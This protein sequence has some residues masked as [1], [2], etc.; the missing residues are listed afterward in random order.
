MPDSFYVIH[1][2]P[3]KVFKTPFFV[4]YGR[5]LSTPAPLRG[6]ILDKGNEPVAVGKLLRNNRRVWAMVFPDVP[7][8][9]DYRLEIKNPASGEV[10][11]VD[12]L[13]VEPVYGITIGYPT[14]DD[15]PVG[16]TFIAYGSTDVTTALDATLTPDGGG[17]ITYLWGPPSNPVYWAFEFDEIEVGSYTMS[18][19]GGGSTANQTVDVL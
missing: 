14:D 12:W 7:K 9:R 2:R 10:R 6:A 15:L 19:A 3:A 11:S 4:A 1:P 13:A 5:W 18:I 17:T 16:T 8:G